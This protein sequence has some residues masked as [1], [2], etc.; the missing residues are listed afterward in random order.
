MHLLNAF[1]LNA[2]KMH[3]NMHLKMHF[4]NAF[5]YILEMHF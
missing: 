2:G 5:K 3:V 4:L 1:F